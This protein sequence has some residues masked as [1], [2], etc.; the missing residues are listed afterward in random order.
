MRHRKTRAPKPPKPPKMVRPSTRDLRNLYR[1][2]VTTDQGQRIARL[3]A[4]MQWFDKQG[5]PYVLFKSGGQYT[6][7]QAK[8]I[9]RATKCRLLGMGTHSN[10][11]KETAYR[12]AVKQYEKACDMLQLPALDL[13]YKDL[14]V[15]AQ[16][17]QTKQE[18]LEAK[19]GTITEMLQKALAPTNVDGKP[20]K[21][22]AGQVSQPFQ[23]DPERQQFT[24]RRDLIKAL[25][26][27]FRREGLLAVV[28]SV[29]DPLSR[30]AAME[31][32][33]DAAGNP[34]GKYLVLGQKRFEKAMLFLDNLIA[35]G[36]LAES[37]KR[38]VRKAMAPPDPNAPQKPKAVR[39]AGAHSPLRG[40]KLMD[41]FVIGSDIAKVFTTLSDGKEHSENE[42]QKMITAQLAGRLHVI[43]TVGR[44][45]MAAGPGWRVERGGG[46]AKLSFSDSAFHQQ[47][48]QA[49]AQVKP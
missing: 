15:K 11:E 21:I 44:T 34:T 49:V 8:Y 28:R 30:M 16:T 7:D 36:K 43:D 14:D 37:P 19:F 38:M 42:L 4:A 32:E 29:I 26:V 23:M 46:K 6:V 24:L 9:D 27:K 35:Y 13:F 17:L 25:R 41:A 45:K 48:Q 5:L 1:G 22:Q 3:S 31:P 12:Q 40:P 20:I 10:A 18:R 39:P 2:L 47:V 33:K